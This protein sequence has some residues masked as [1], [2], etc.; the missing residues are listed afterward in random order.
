MAKNI[1]F[2][3]G[4]KVSGELVISPTQDDTLTKILALDATG[5]VYW[6]NK[7]SA[8]STTDLSA[9]ST[10]SQNDGRYYLATNPNSYITLSALTWANVSGKPTI[11]TNT[12]QLTNGSGFI[13]AEVD[14]LSSVTSRGASTSNQLTIS[15]LTSTGAIDLNAATRLVIPTAST[16]T[17]NG[18]WISNAGSTGS[19]N[20][21]VSSLATLTDVGLTTLSNNQFLQF[22]T[23]SGK[24]TNATLNVDLTSYYTKTESDGKYYLS[25][26]PNS[27]ITLTALTWNNVTGKPTI[28]TN[29]NQLTNGAGFISAEVD[30][31]QTVTARGASSSAAINLTGSLTLPTGSTVL[32]NSIWIGAAGSTGTTNP[33][34]SSLSTLTDVNITSVSNAQALTYNT[35][36]GK[37]VNS[38]IVTDLSAY[39]TKN[40]TDTKF[41]TGV[42]FGIISG[43]P[44]T[45]SG[46]GILDAYTKIESDNRFSSTAHTHTYASIT[47]KPTTIGGYSITDAYTKSEVD[48]R[49]TTGVSFS[50][51]TSK[52]STIV[53]YGITD[54]YTKVEGDSRFS[55]TAHTHSF[56]VLTGKPTT[57]AGF[58][59][60]DAF[61]K[62][63]SDA[64]YSLTAHTHTFASLTSRPTTLA[65]YAIS[66]AYTNTQIDNVFSGATVASGYNKSNW[67]TAFSWGSPTLQ[68]VTGKGN[69]TTLAIT[70][71]GI[72]STGVANFN[73]VTS[74]ILP[75]GSTTTNNTIW[76]GSAGSTASTNN[77]VSSLGTLTD[78][79]LTSPTNNQALTYNSTS[80]KWVNSTVVTDLSSYSTTAQAD[81][82]YY[83]A[84]NPNSFITLTALTFTNILNKPTTLAGY[85]ITDAL[86][87]NSNAVSATLTDKWK[88]NT[89][90][91]QAANFG[92]YGGIIQDSTTGP[93]NGIWYNKIKILHNNSA[94]YFT[95][96]AMSFTST[97]GVY[98][99]RNDAGTISAWATFLDSDNFNSYSP[100]LTG[101]GASGT[102]GIAISGNAATATN[103]TN[104]SKSTLVSSPDG[105]RLANTKLP[106]TSPNAVR[107]DFVNASAV[108]TGGNY[109]GLMTYAPYD[110][111]S[112]ST[113][114]ASYQLVFGGTA[115][116]ASGMPMLRIRKGIDSTWN[117][118]Y[119]LLHSGNYT[120]YAPTL[121]GTGASGT[122]GIS[123]TG[124]AATSTNTRYLPNRT[125]ATSYP[126]V[127]GADQ[128]GSNS[129]LFSCT[130]V[131]IQSSTGQITANQFNGALNGK[132]SNST[133]WNGNTYTGTDVAVNTY[134]MV[135][136]ADNTWHP[137]SVSN[138]KTFL[139]L[140]SNAYSSASFIQNNGAGD[141]QIASNSVGTNYTTA[142]LEL[143]ERDFGATSA[144]EAPRLAF[145]WAGLVASQISIES[146]GT[147][148]IL[149]NPGTGYENLKAKV[150]TATEGVILP[151][152]QPPNLTNGL[153]WIA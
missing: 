1:P 63:E 105:D 83:L 107:F 122:W 97:R 94:G 125:D 139:G 47:S 99:R 100:T 70:T 121:T 59:I 137:S 116:N 29:T 71:A 36:S 35:A 148:T 119:D 152:S 43:K 54:S 10:T 115:A 26:N 5:K 95:E 141:W 98:H 51:I 74:F 21:V 44:T 31:L 3:N 108:G 118:F 79:S 8:G 109:A 153:I 130:G 2:L 17:N 135:F 58:G 91:L 64:K 117:T 106:T 126:V 96:L 15:G 129:P 136:G 140:G 113:G 133:Q 40:E 102:W 42:T 67:D 50:N 151:T 82:K 12:N 16:V 66:D 46:Y 145:H 24:W 85:G 88:L 11:P 134:M 19:S 48:N 65:G 138:I 87:I 84:T 150:V 81:A 78:V 114:D 4:I 110:G 120:S 13:S 92:D 28:P 60:T 112:T 146:N 76:L 52:P 103:A 30:T 142:T 132:A 25:S 41:L 128:G 57:V 22:N 93:V 6:T 80:G 131:T 69:T 49:I 144:F 123:V 23:A 75:T 89:T 147:I 143:R 111:T 62:T 53:G 68:N 124:N 104:A 127:W 7:S 77:V 149:N 34:V 86:G 27:Y 72:T 33:V 73:G 39:Y 56:A 18:I 55:G 90:G 37:W 45:L 9:Y 61:T 101:T 14:T 32:N 20:P 38:T